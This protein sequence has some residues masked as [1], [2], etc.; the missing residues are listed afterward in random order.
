MPA[1]KNKDS[2]T[3][4]TCLA[5][6]L[7]SYYASCECADRHLNPLNTNL[8]VADTSRT[9]KTICLAVSP[10][11]KACGI[12]GRPRLFEVIQKVKEINIERLNTL[13][14]I[15]HNPEAEFT[16]ASFDAA[17]LKKDPWLKL[18]YITAPPRMAR[19]VETSAQIYSI[20][21]K[22]I[23]P[24]DIFAYSIDEVFIDATAY[25]NTY[26][27]SAHELAMTMIRE[28]LYTT[29][30]TATGGI[31]SNLYLAKVAM[32]IVAKHVPADR[33]GVRIAELDEYSYRAR[34]WTHT[35]LT[36]FWRVGKATA[37]KLEQHYL[38]TMGDI[39]QESLT[40]PEWVYKFFGIDAE[41]LID[42]AWE[43]E[44]V[45]MKHIRNYKA[46]N[47][48]ISEGQVLSEPYEYSKARI[49]VR[50]MADSLVMQLVEKRLTTDHLTLDISYDRENIDKGRHSGDSKIDY[51]GRLV[52]KP[53]HGS[54]RFHSPTSLSS[55]I[56]EASVNLFDRIADRNLTVRKITLAAGHVSRDDGIYQLNLF[57]DTEKQ[58]REKKLQEAMLSIRKRYGKNALL[59]GTSY[60]D[61]A[62]M[63]ERNGQIGG[64]RSGE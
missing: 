47:H 30:I 44:P 46:D 33:D 14:R 21:L 25:L 60:L 50:E 31:G 45:T 51:Y 54:C 6:D 19:Y 27:M 34:L 37:R 2:L 59:K 38:Y 7:K 26:H 64:H 40:N 49:I 63:R 3:V 42:H 56:T 41:I 15:S 58:E 61:G 18:S 55:V 29:G 52:P 36:D 17:A 8:V 13:R 24:E 35:P 1:E 62:T 32:D 16:S 22:Y 10:S 5:I 4:R 39:A 20:Y 12:S 48:S 43:I 28:V 57:A 9:E 53:A 23:A 11:L